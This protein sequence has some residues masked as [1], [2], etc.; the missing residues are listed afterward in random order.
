MFGFSPEEQWALT[1]TT[2]AGLSTSLGGIL[3]IVRRPDDTML[4]FLLGTAIGVMVSLSV[5]E[6]W[7]HNAVQHGWPGVTFAVL[8]GA[9]LYRIISPLLPDFDAATELTALGG[10]ADTQTKLLDR[11]SVSAAMESTAAAMSE[12]NG[13]GSL[14][15]FK[16]G[17]VPRRG[18][19]TSAAA[20][21][22]VLVSGR[23]DA[24]DR[25]REGGDVMPSTAGAAVAAVAAEIEDDKELKN[26]RRSAE[27]LRLGF[28]MA[29]T[30][31]LH[32]APEGFAGEI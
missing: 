5:I 18:D 12:S 10:S 28:L 4:A 6:M 16:S 13:S 15:P 21:D 30:M 14:P 24:G 26:V 19:A 32:N 22:A 27:L 3:A 8:C 1:L 31:T 7:I 9:L 23:K 17:L 20:E 2:F 29:V 11:N 25:S